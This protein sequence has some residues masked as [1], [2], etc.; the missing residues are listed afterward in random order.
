[1][2]ISENGIQFYGCEASKNKRKVF[3]CREIEIPDD[4]ETVILGFG[5]NEVYFHIKDAKK[6][7]ENVKKLVIPRNV[8]SI[9]IPNELFPNVRE[10]ES[11]SKY[12]DSGKYLITC[13]GGYFNHNARMLINSFCI[14]KDEILDM[15]KITAL[16]KYALSGCETTTVINAEDVCAIDTLSFYGSAIEMQKPE[17]NGC[18]TFGNILIN[19]DDDA[20]EL[21]IPPNIRMALPGIVVSHVKRLVLHGAGAINMFIGS[22]E[23][24][25]FADDITENDTY[26]LKNKAYN[27][28]KN[29]EIMPGNK[30][31]KIVDGVIYKDDG[32]Y[33]VKCPSSKTGEFVVPEVVKQIG[34]SAFSECQIS[35]ITLPDSLEVIE[36]YAFESCHNLEKVNFGNGI[37]IRDIGYYIMNSHSYINLFYDCDNLKNIV[38]PRQVRRIGYGAF[39]YSHLESIELN[40]GLEEIREFAFAN[41]KVKKIKIP[42]TVKKIE[43]GALSRVQHVIF[44]ADTLPDN[45]IYAFINEQVPDLLEIT[46]GGENGRSVIVIRPQE[47]DCRKIRTFDDLKNFAAYRAEDITAYFLAKECEKS[48]AKMLEVNEYSSKILEKLLRVIPGDKI[49]FAAILMDAIKR[50][51]GQEKL[52]EKTDT[53]LQL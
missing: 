12:F 13:A 35:S 31:F 17:K 11:Q 34:G 21:E 4:M 10:V 49:L 52:S 48:F 36:D 19:I 23:T 43:E 53:R 46:V 39:A 3:F 16:G 7:Y 20:E 41:S 47:L 5:E 6:R 30:C 29:Y 50:K 15:D 8:T 22:P 27:R 18:I 40:E 9:H 32:K 33:L 51:K 14:R 1:M 2:M 38:L 28:V 26:F 37:G 45:A 24:V 25:V 42:K 44:E